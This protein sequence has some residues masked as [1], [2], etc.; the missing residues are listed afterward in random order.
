MMGIKYVAAVA[1]TL[2]TLAVASADERLAGKW[3]EQKSDGRWHLKFERGE[4]NAASQ[5]WTGTFEG[6]LH[7]TGQ[8]HRG[9]YV[10]TTRD[11]KSGALTLLENNKV[12]ATAHVDVE[13]RHLT[14]GSA[15]YH[16]E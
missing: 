9:V 4:Y 1:V 13:R 14:Y 16:R 11:G 8:F 6:H 7:H 10:W 2:G 12:F 3:K 15:H 5:T